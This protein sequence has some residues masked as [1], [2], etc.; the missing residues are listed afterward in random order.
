[1]MRVFFYQA[2]NVKIKITC[3]ENNSRGSNIDRLMEVSTWY[4]I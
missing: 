1:M 4:G 3:N 2:N